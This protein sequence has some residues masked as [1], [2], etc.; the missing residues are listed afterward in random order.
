MLQRTEQL[1]ITENRTCLHKTD[2][3]MKFLNLILSNWIL[4]VSF[5][6]Q[7]ALS[8]P[9]AMAQGDFSSL[10]FNNFLLVMKIYILK[11]WPLEFD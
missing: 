5:T 1:Y 6:I 10:S 7:N 4:Y 11:I 9:P 2:L 3:F 8:L